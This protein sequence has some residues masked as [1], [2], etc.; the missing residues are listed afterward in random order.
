MIADV[1]DDCEGGSLHI[2][3]GVGL[4]VPHS[5]LIAHPARAVAD[6]NAPPSLHSL[7]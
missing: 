6:A 4:T 7:T 1:Y 2:E 5:D 3:T